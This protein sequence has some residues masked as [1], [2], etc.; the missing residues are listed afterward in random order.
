MVAGGLAAMFASLPVTA[1]MYKCK[2][3]NGEVL[4]S[5]SPCGG[6]LSGEE[7]KVYTKQSAGPNVVD[8]NRIRLLT[9]RG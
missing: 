3:A 4:Y 9:R 1:G 2:S 5:G 6:S 7:V 8:D